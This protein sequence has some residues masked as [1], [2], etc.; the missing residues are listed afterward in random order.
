MG[1]LSA[2]LLAAQGWTV[3]ATGRGLDAITPAD[4]DAGIRAVRLDLGALA[5]VDAFAE[6]LPGLG[7]PPI[8]A[9]V[10][11]A[12]F[13]N[14]GRVWSEDGYEATVAVNYLAQLR[15]IDRLVPL[16][17]PSARI[18]WTASGTHDP[19]EVRM[20]PKALE[21]ATLDELLHPEAHPARPIRDGFQRYAASKLCVV[22]VVPFLARDLLGRATVNAFDPGLMPG[23]GLGRGQSARIQTLWNVVAPLALLAPGSHR[24][25]TSARHLAQLVTSLRFAAM[26]GAYVVDDHPAGTS[27][28][29]Y[30]VDAGERL[31]RDSLALAGAQL[32]GQGPGAAQL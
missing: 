4:R 7:L 19:D 20:L 2:R 16:L 13:Q 10:C 9:V 28:A 17:A 6:S 31:Y 32:L 5:N 27:I 18:V 14:P 15:L 12:G 21:S 25:I 22:R 1:L 24:P 23:T 26:T 8:S 29:S 3:V 30:D 11:N